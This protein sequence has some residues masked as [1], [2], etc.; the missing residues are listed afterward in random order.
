ME[1]LG[2]RCF[3]VVEQV[4]QSCAGGGSAGQV[5][6]TATAWHGSMCGQPQGRL[7]WLAVR[8]PYQGLGLAKALLCA[9]TASFIKHGHARAFLTTQT[10]S[11]RAI[12]LCVLFWLICV[13]VVMP[14]DPQCAV[15]ALENK[16]AWVG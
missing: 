12:R 14:C 1:E 10:T 7:H 11:A 3:F 6:G 16:V 8:E 5:V 15:Q 9:V 4:V 13:D 2:R